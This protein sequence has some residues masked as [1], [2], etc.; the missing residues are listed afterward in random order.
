MTMFKQ[1]NI[2]Q[3]CEL[4]DK[5]TVNIA[6]IRDLASF[7]A[8]HIP[9]AQHLDNDSLSGYISK[10]PQDEALVVCCYHGNS[11]QG[12]AQYLAEQGYKDVYSLQ[13]GFELW[14]VSQP[15]AIEQ[16]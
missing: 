12:A 3:L 6:D 9:N 5:Q 16:G 10:T 14:K 11:S 1:I 15:D 13:G 7:Q 8:G 2:Q 4:K